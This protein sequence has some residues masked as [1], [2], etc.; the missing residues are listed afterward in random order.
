MKTAKVIHV[1]I[2][3]FLLCTSVGAYTLGEVRDGIRAHEMQINSLR[4]VQKNTFYPTDGFPDA[5]SGW[6]EDY[7]V[8]WDA[9][10]NMAW[11]GLN[12]TAAKE[13]DE[14][15]ARQW[16]DPSFK[17]FSWNNNRFIEYGVNTHTAF[18]TD[19]KPLKP[20]LQTPFMTSFLGYSC[21]Y[22]DQYL[23][24]SETMDKYGAKIINDEA[25]SI[26]GR[27]T[28]VVEVQM[29]YPPDSP[30]AG[31]V[32]YKMLFWICPELQFSPLKMERR[33]QRPTGK[34]NRYY[35]VRYQDVEGVFLPVSGLYAAYDPDPA[36]GALK[37]LAPTCGYEFSQIRVNSGPASDLI[38]ITF[39][40][41]T[42]VIDK[43]VQLRYTIGEDS[44]VPLNRPF[45]SI[46][47]IV[48]PETRAVSFIDLKANKLYRVNS[49]GIVAPVTE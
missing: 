22:Y 30:R 41:G 16:R 19:D 42:T 38:D 7:T 21:I 11:Q 48:D 29:P 33:S 49:S 18:I 27:E 20:W 8:Y 10:W 5:L 34:V 2:L 47:K 31:E 6:Y 3:L 14:N 12:R 36:A 17:S 24:L 23:T 32:Y 25:T 4:Y 44:V 40:T 15:G 39:P 45:E 9:D 37:Q 1:T 13:R 26:D 43:K 28:V 35:D 46:Q